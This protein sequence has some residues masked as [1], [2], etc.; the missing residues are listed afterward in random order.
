MINLGSIWCWDVN[1]NLLDLRILPLPHQTT[2]PAI[3][4]YFLFVST[5]FFDLYLGTDE[6]NFQGIF[7]YTNKFSRC[8]KFLQLP[9]VILA[10][11]LKKLAKLFL[12]NGPIPASFSVY[13][14]LFNMS[15]FKL[16][17]RR[18]CAWESNPGGRLEGANESTVLR[19]HPWPNF[20]PKSFATLKNYVAI[21]VI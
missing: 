21:F 4:T 8:L 3:L 10:F 1:C 12:K 6:N 19:R 2:A 16:K 9:Q 11:K 7:Y 5:I 14:R 15:Q 20:L 17:K 18:W 13:F